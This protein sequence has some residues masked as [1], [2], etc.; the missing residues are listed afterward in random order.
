MKVA[1]AAAEMRLG[2]YVSAESVAAYD[3]HH[4]QEL[5]QAGQGCPSCCTA[6]MLHETGDL[7][8]LHTCKGHLNRGVVFSA[9]R[10]SRHPVH[11]YGSHRGQRQHVEPDI[12]PI[13]RDP[14]NCHIKGNLKAGRVLVAAAVAQF[15]GASVQMTVACLARA[16]PRSTP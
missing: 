15:L 1:I 10:P 7:T 11:R 16:F 6:P 4:F 2:G 9:G 14:L 13:S 12:S 8:A 3:A 5:Y